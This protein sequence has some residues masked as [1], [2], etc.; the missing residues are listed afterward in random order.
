VG[1]LY[2]GTEL[3]EAVTETPGKAAYRV[4]LLQS[5]SSAAEVVEERLEPTGL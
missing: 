2:R 4:K 3:V 5:G 1:L